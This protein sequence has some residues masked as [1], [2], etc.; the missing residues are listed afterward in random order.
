MDEISLLVVLAPGWD[1]EWTV[2]K[3]RRRQV[4]GMIGRADLE[5]TSQSI[6]N[7]PSENGT[8]RT[9]RFVMAVL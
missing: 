8:S 3:T 2:S 1:N 6:V 4:S 7:A 5:E 9:F